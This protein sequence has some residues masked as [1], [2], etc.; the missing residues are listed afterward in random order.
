MNREKIFKASRFKA[1]LLFGVAGLFAWTGL[2]M[3]ASQPLFGGAT[4]LLFGAIAL[5]GALV[6][7][8]GGVTLRLDEEG[9]EMVGLFKTSHFRWSDIESIRMAKIRGATVIALNYK[10]G[11]A[12]RS[13]VSRSLTGMDAAVGNM[14]NISLKDLAET[15]IEWHE[16]YGNAT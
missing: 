5:I 15:L 11:G 12:R 2:H 6:L 9:V 16:R 13:Q 7:V 10:S 8:K 14:Y 3:T 4:A 1:L